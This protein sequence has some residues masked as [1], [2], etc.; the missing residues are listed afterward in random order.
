MRRDVILFQFNFFFFLFKYKK[1]N[2]HGLNKIGVGSLNYLIDNNFWRVHISFPI[3]F[4]LKKI[5][6]HI[7]IVLIIKKKKKRD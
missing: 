4:F 1:K 5:K 6:N 2:I 7:K 3:F